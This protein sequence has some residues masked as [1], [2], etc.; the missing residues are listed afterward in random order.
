MNRC[1]SVVVEL[2]FY[3]P[4]IVCVGSVLVFVLVCIA[5]CHFEVCNHLAEEEMAGC[6]A[7]NVFWM[8]CYCKCSV[9]LPHGAFG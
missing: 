4:L 8:S 5:L 1:G 3:V 6:T 9:A 2:L 7:F